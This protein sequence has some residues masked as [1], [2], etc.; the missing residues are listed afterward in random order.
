METKQPKWK[1]VG[2]VGDVDPISYGGGFVFIDETGIYPPELAWFEPATDE[3][4]HEKGEESKLEYFRVVLEKDSSR[5]WWYSR[6]NEITSFLGVSL[7]ELQTAAKSENP[8]TLAQLYSSL[9]AFYGAEEFDS[10]PVTLTEK[11]ANEKFSAELRFC[12]TGKQ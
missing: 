8:L 10:Y 1:I 7:E 6:L 11:E 5:E 2:H 3:E 9:I 4:W 12:R